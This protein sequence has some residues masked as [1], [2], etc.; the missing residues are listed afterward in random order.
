MD[1]ILKIRDAVLK[2]TKDIRTGEIKT[3]SEERVDQEE[4]LSMLR[5]DIMTSLLILIEDEAASVET[6]KV[7]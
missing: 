5:M 3:C 2:R 4:F 1:M 6:L 7:I